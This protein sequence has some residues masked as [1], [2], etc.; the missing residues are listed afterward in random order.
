LVNDLSTLQID[1][2]AMNFPTFDLEIDDM[3]MNLPILDLETVDL[4]NFFSGFFNL[5]LIGML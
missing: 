2:L 5:L 1:D 4:V 3:A